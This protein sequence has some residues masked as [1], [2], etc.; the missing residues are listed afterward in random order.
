MSRLTL[1]EKLDGY[2]KIVELS[3]GRRHARESFEWKLSLAMWS[4]IVGATVYLGTHYVPNNWQCTRLLGAAV[5]F[6]LYFI[7]AIGVMNG[8]ASD[9]DTAR[10]H[11]K[12]ATAMLGTS[13]AHHPSIAAWG[14]WFQLGTTAL[15]L[16]GFVLL[17]QCFNCT[18]PRLC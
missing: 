6:S 17:G 3:H 14:Q 1:K 12:K 7:F 11:L 9:R 10:N 15:L 5:V 16:A 2:L 4:L 18:P 8:H 13:V